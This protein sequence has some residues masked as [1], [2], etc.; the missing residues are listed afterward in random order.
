MYH[1][2]TKA[3]VLHGFY[4]PTSLAEIASFDAGQG[5]DERGADQQDRQHRAHRHSRSPY[6]AATT[7]RGTGWNCCQGDGPIA[8]SCPNTAAPMMI[9][10]TCLQSVPRSDNASA[11]PSAPA[12]TPRA[13][14]REQP[15]TSHFARFL[16]H[17][18]SRQQNRRACTQSGSSWHNNDSV[19]APS[20]RT[21]PRQR[22][23]GK[24]RATSACLRRWAIRTAAARSLRGVAIDAHPEFTPSRRS[25]RRPA[26]IPA[27]RLGTGHGCVCSGRG[28]V[29][30]ARVT[31][32]DHGR[33]W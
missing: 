26:P 21:S 14:H 10:G 29:S 17:G 5:R 30:A 1:G 6:L 19:A 22:S 28:A 25:T 31:T 20:M 7:P 8:N 24:I 23:D 13:E 11:L 4:S 32:Q 27:A 3:R 33:G 12:T 16:A 9:N 18:H 15:R 2:A